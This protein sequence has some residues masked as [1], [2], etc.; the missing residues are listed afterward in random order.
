VRPFFISD[1]RMQH[2]V[3]QAKAL[4]IL[5]LLMLVACLAYAPGLHG[6][7]LFDDFA[8]L[9]ALGSTGPIDN[10]PAF[11]RY[12]T[13]G[14]A[15]P[16]GRPLTMLSFLLNAHD[17]PAN[18]IPFKCTNLLLH[19]INGALLYALLLRL[20]TTLSGQ[21]TSSCRLAAL[22]G[23]ALWL[24]H[25]LLVSTTLYIVQREAMLPATI[26][27]A[28]LLV[29]LR[30]RARLAAGRYRAGVVYYLGGLGLGTLLG[31]L[32][33]AN[34]ALL[35]LYALLI[36][37]IV[38]AAKDPLPTEPARRVHR[39][40]MFWL[41]LLP[42]IALLSYLIYTG[43][44]GIGAGQLPRGRPWTYGQRLLT[45]PRVLLQYL[46]LLW[47][48]H[49]FSNGLF[50]DQV[51]VSTSLWSPIS[52]LPAMLLVLALIGLGWLLRRKHPALALAILFYFAGQLVESTSIPL[53][54][55]YEH[56]N[57]LPALVMFWP[58]ALWLVEGKS[59]PRI[60]YAMILI[61]PLCL[62]LMTYESARV[63]GD[64]RQQ[65]LLWAYINPESPRAQANA[66]QIEMQTGKPREAA[67]RLQIALRSHPAEPQLALNLIGA[68]CMLGG[69][70]D[71]DL[72]AA[73]QSMLTAP[74]TGSLFVHWFD[75]MLPAVA[76]G[77]CPGLTMAAF[78]NLIDA[79]AEN[80]RMSASGPQ[81]DFTYL[82][83]RIALSQG[84][85]NT[86]VAD[87]S[88]ALDL[89]IRPDIALEGAATLGAAGYPAQG[90]CLLD[91]FESVQAKAIP[92][93]VGMPL[94]HQWVLQQQNYWPKEVA[95]LR[96][97]LIQDKVKQSTASYTHSC[98]YA[99]NT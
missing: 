59:V 49:P 7:F 24:L 60:R 58:L 68:H 88:K 18:P 25:P 62:A 73:R 2:P 30:G 37:R 40:L 72:R 3:T 55:Y 95:H 48:P 20:S 81:Q 1:S 85:A 6:G 64:V 13:S 83:G 99:T 67:E 27:L 66:A 53:E 39:Q 47:V 33:K 75:R 74:T 50:N 42:S 41:A 43:I 63:W 44:H 31:V 54:L 29:W 78:Q 77:Q 26:V 90:L 35:P 79:G 11:W 86:A 92:P 98:N 10:W 34:G 32:A 5:L 16:T 69:T 9:P 19:L 46:T 80:P 96:A 38:L 23:T 4:L 93:D 36:D 57:Y 91:H 84:D 65:A 28:G 97:Q 17:W 52:T 45:E 22:I 56:R 8:N 70:T 87:F 21:Q 71:D 82:R 12:I 94:L 76:R 15:D 51:V 14:T 61:L 89:Q